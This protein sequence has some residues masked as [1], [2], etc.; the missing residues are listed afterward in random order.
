[1]RTP[2]RRIA[3]ALAIVL[4]L[5]A[6]PVLTGCVGQVEGV[7]ENV[8]GGEVDLGGQSVPEDFPADVPI[9]D[10]DVVYGVSAGSAD[11]KVWNVTVSVADAT[12][13]DTIKLELEDA[14]FTTRLEGPANADGGTLA[15][16]SAAYGVLVAVTNG[17]DGFVANYT[18]TANPA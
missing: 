11:G 12:A 6:A 5:A 8:T 15:A 13:L 16:D 17:T 3:V 10:G 1:M 2:R 18:V 4:T 9:T 7:I 14:G